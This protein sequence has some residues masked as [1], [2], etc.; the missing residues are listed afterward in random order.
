[1]SAF[2]V[3]HD[4]I[5]ALLTFAKEKRLE[6]QIFY[7]A[8]QGREPLS[9]TR[10]G[11]ILLAENER[12]V[13]QRYPDVVPG[14][15]PGVIGEEAINYT[16]RPFQPFSLMQ[17]PTKLAWVIKGC[18]CYDYQACETD[19]YEQS[20]AYRIINVIRGRAI[21]GLPGYEDAPWEI[22]RDRAN[23]THKG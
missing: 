23:A 18:N 5:D 4:H 13:C 6:S 9:W 22:H 7:I 2:V 3:S 16:F 11:Q 19:D 8:N 1:M 10:I 20:I 21:N 17:Y 14:E 15:G 12:S